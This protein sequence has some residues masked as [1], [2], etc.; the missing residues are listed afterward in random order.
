VHKTYSLCEGKEQR[1]DSE[2]ERL[3]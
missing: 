1:E 3:E 2:I